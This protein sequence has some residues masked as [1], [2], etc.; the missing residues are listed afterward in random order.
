MTKR[1]RAVRAITIALLATA[2][3]VAAEEAVA[4]AAPEQVAAVPLASSPS[5]TLRWAVL[6]ANGGGATDSA[7]YRAEVTVGQTAIGSTAG[8]AGSAQLG[9]W[10]G[11]TTGLFSDGFESGDTSAWDSTVGG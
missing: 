3:P 6:D 10:Y 7:G 1:A 8:P 4:P 9:F 2:A 5:Y 11:V